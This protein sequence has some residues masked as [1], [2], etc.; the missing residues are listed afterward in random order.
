M[1]Q[2]GGPCR[3]SNYIS[4]LRAALR[5]N[6]FENIPVISL[7]LGNA[8]GAIRFP[9]TPQLIKKAVMAMI[10]GDLLMK[11]LFQVRPYERLPG[12]ADSLLQSWLG[13]CRKS[14]RCDGREP[15]RRNLIAIA[16]DFDRLEVK[17]EKR[18]QVG[19]V[20]EIMVKYHPAAN[21]HMAEFLER[22]NAEMV[23]PNLTTF[24][25]IAPWAGVQSPVHGWGKSAE[26]LWESLRPDD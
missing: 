22:T 17:P 19:L 25:F 4:L 12:S 2:T 13:I 21:N 18:I 9:I 23:V 11:L 15:F 1:P 24:F 26:T 3:A 8:G 10:Y 5:K 6:G 7:T 14:V 20:G 16:R